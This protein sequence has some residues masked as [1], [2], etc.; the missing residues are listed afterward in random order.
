[1]GDPERMDQCQAKRDGDWE[2]E[3][4]GA[5]EPKNSLCS[6]ESQV[7]NRPVVPTQKFLGGALV[8]IKASQSEAI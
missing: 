8:I 1:M 3:P 4:G 2:A 5:K 7:S 6:G